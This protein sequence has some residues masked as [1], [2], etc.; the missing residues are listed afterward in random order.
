MRNGEVKIFFVRRSTAHTRSHPKRRSS[1]YTYTMPLHSAAGRTYS[2]V[3]LPSVV[4][5]NSWPSTIAQLFD[6]YPYGA[7]RV[8][9]T[10]YPTN[11]KRQYIGQFSDAQTNLDYLISRYYDSAR[12]QF[13]SEDPV[14]W[15]NPKDQDLLN[16]QSLNSYSYA[17]DNPITK[18]DPTGK[19]TLDSLLSKLSG[20]LTQLLGVLRSSGSSISSGAASSLSST[21]STTGAVLANVAGR[22]PTSSNGGTVANSTPS[23]IGLPP[24]TSGAM[25]GLTRTGINDGV[26]GPNST[27]YF[28]MGTVLPIIASGGAWALP[29]AG[30]PVAGSIL[31]DATPIGSALK[32]DAYHLAA[33]FMR[34][35]AA[36]SGK[37]TEFVGGDGLTYT[38]VEVQGSIDGIKGTFKYIVDQAGNLTHQFFHVGE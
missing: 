1:V 17:E 36:Q 3:L 12:G 24:I 25:P 14:F 6:Y 38:K 37:V 13:V 28:L 11:Q 35:V 22:G 26:N 33:R 21:L 27:D 31:S 18:K 9:S 23:V 30:A 2:R 16:P 7:T 10:T 5:Q 15:G 8:S 19:S 29:E 4:V 20:V 34:D 32:G